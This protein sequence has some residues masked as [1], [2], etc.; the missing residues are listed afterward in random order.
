MTDVQ[1]ARLYDSLDA[2]VCA[3]IVEV[4]SD[5]ENWEKIRFTLKD[6]E[7]NPKKG[8]LMIETLPNAVRQELSGHIQTH[9]RSTGGGADAVATFRQ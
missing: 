9:S 4:S 8:V 5:G 6:K 7:H 2:V 3:G 1:Q